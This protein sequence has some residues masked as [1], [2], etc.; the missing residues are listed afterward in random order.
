MISKRYDWSIIYASI[1][2]ILYI[3]FLCTIININYKM[4]FAYNEISYKLS[5]Y[6]NII[7]VVVFII[8]GI[9]NTEVSI[10]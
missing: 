9:L 6:I 7:C 4:W 3:V 2:I 10:F 8:L 1:Y 5:T